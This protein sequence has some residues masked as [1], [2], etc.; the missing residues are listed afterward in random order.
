[1]KLAAVL[2]Y[3]GRFYCGWQSQPGVS[4]VQES[5]EKVLFLLEKKKVAVRVAGRTDAGV[6]AKGQVCVFDYYK[7]MD[8]SRLKLA[9]NAN[10]DN[11]IR[12]MGIHRVGN[13]FDPRKDALWREYV[14]FIWNGSE[15]YP[16]ISNF[17]W[18]NKFGWNDQDVKKACTYLEGKHDF[19]SFCKASECP[20]NSVR[21][22][23]KVSFRRKGSLGILRV[24]G[25]AFLMNMVRTMAGSLDLVGRKRKK[26]EWIN[27]LF[28]FPSRKKAGPTAPASGLFLWRVG[29]DEF[30]S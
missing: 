18:W 24:R 7:E 22:L 16:H 11:S 6:H 2:A 20:E 10:L 12:V 4:T 8:L 29:Y 3:D 26:A 27:E 9:I 17:V 28:D 14:Y 21:E 25:N 15:C 13:E 30:T 23:Y 1:M 19:A 5:I